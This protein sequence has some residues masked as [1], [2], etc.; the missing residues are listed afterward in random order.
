MPV[1]YPLQHRRMFSDNLKKILDNDRLQKSSTSQDAVEVGF[2]L[3]CSQMIPAAKDAAYPI[4]QVGAF[5]LFHSPLLPH[6]SPGLHLLATPFSLRGSLSL[7]SPS[8]FAPVLV[9]DLTLALPEHSSQVTHDHAAGG[10]W[11]DGGFKGLRLP[12]TGNLRL[13][14]YLAD[15]KFI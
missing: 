1:S 4:C 9:T 12:P 5:P 7:L 13:P 14:T 15:L 8:L 3:A 2:P 6:S 11:L 10:L